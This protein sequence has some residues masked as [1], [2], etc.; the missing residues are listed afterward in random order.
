MVE[1]SWLNLSSINPVWSRGDKSLLGN[2]AS[3][4]WRRP[5]NTL[6]KV[7]LSA[8]ACVRT[9]V[10][11]QVCVCKLVHVFVQLKQRTKSGLKT[12][13]M[14]N[15]S[16][17]KPRKIEK[18]WPHRAT[19]AKS[20]TTNRQGAFETKLLFCTFENK[21]KKA[22]SSFQLS[23]VTLCAKRARGRPPNREQSLFYRN[24]LRVRFESWAFHRAL[25]K[26]HT[27]KHIQFNDGWK[28]GTSF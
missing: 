19:S 12:R 21:T 15:A 11:V 27:A 20:T 25:N 5:L 2:K 26:K 7:K 13:A 1:S 18:R 16:N 9:C 28:S 17:Q 24:S 3:K 14:K 8:C 4:L 22:A 23:A 6:Q 10:C